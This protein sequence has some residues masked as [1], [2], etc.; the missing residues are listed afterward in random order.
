[1]NAPHIGDQGPLHRYDPE[2]PFLYELEREVLRSARSAARD[3]ARA[4]RLKPSAGASH[5]IS[6]RIEGARL[7]AAGRPSQRSRIRTKTRSPRQAL[8]P[9]GSRIARRSL[10]L[11]VLLCLIG[12]SAY[13]ARQ[14][15]E[16]GDSSPA[17]V[18][19]SALVPVAHGHSGPDT[20]SLHLY[21]RGGELCRVLVVG[22]TESS[23]CSLAPRARLFGVTSMV[24]PSRR[25]VYGV[26]AAGITHVSIHT[27]S[28]TVAVS[29]HTPPTAAAHAAGLPSGARW[30]LAILRRPIGEPDPAVNV[31]GLDAGGRPI[32]H[33][34]IDCPETPE[35]Q[36]CRR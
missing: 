30:F 16:G 34:F 3:R 31:R 10:M 11:M 8:R 13:G 26:S 4:Q 33:T 35:P 9:T 1:M 24:S 5:A 19:Q 6:A 18:H 28:T 29:T 22:E 2:L 20:W 23:R 17:V 14:I 21:I 36:S 12:A 15:L 27:G 32:T 7:P 25:Y